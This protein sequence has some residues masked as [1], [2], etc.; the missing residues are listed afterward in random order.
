MKP[1]VGILTIGTEITTGQIVNTNGPFLGQKL[2][3]IQYKSPIHI[4]VPDDKNYITGA[5]EYLKKRVSFILTTG[6]LG[7]TS[8]DFTR[9][10]I[11]SWT[12]KNLEHDEP[13]WNQ[14]KKRLEKRSIHPN[15]TNKQQCLYPKGAQILENSIGTANGFILDHNDIK[16]ICLPGPPHEVHHLFKQH[17]ADFFKDQNLEKKETHLMRW[18]LLGCSE[19]D[20]GEI[21]ESAINGSTLK[22]GYR[23]NIPYVEVKIWSPEK[24]AEANKPYILKLNEDL[25]PWTKFKDDEDA[26]HIF[27]EKLANQ[28]SIVIYDQASKGCLQKRLAMVY[29]TIDHKKP[30]LKILS[31]WPPKSSTKT[32]RDQC[33][34]DFFIHLHHNSADK[35]DTVKVI[36]QGKQYCESLEPPFSSKARTM[37]EEYISE[38]AIIVLIK[39]IIPT[40]EGQAT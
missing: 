1:T 34:N 37:H 23:P 31:S 4:S 20:L 10:V 35:C 36:Y 27:F 18:H 6:G 13:S 25:K 17:L 12:K 38:L 32:I 11:A 8:D 5:L 22:S 7:P 14:I 21:V 16:I 9:N 28:E 30:N 2:D 29:N 15:P 24:D 3:D 33:K 40:I 19:A 39:K 26:A